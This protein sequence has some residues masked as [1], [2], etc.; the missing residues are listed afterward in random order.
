MDPERKALAAQFGVGEVVPVPTVPTH[1]PTG[2]TPMPVRSERHALAPPKGGGSGYPSPTR[3]APGEQNNF[4]VGGAR[5]DAGSLGVMAKQA[6][7][8]VQAEQAVGYRPVRRPPVGQEV[9]AVAV[10]LAR[11]GQSAPALTQGS[12]SKL[13]WESLEEMSFEELVKMDAKADFQMPPLPEFKGGKGGKGGGVRG[14]QRGRPSRRPLPR[15]PRQRRRRLPPPS[16]SRRRRRSLRRRRPY[17]LSTL[18]PAPPLPR[19]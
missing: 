16:R 18:P 13:T 6:V 4:A 12:P 5:D 19:R 1:A 14:H 11:G 9:D 17:R 7:A 3:R 8:T 10:A 2:W 15:S